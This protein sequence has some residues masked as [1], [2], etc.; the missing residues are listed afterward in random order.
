[1]GRAFAMG[2]N[3]TVDWRK[4]SP[5]LPRPAHKPCRLI[6]FPT[7]YSRPQKLSPRHSPDFN[8]D[9][10]AD[11]ITA[12]LRQIKI[13]GE[14]STPICLLEATPMGMVANDATTKPYRI[15]ATIGIL[16]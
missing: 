6:P 13:T 5:K 3:P 10:V 14:S 7:P 16:H 2:R 9:S 4:R 8:N 12:G 15:L 11:W 1:M